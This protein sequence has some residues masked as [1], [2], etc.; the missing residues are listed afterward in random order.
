MEEV[1]K[2]LSKHKLL[3]KLPFS[4]DQIMFDKYKHGICACI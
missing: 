1:K 3:D 4:N 2:H